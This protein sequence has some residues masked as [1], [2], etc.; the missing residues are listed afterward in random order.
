MDDIFVGRQ[1]IYNSKL[2]VMAYELLYRSNR[3]NHAQFLDG[4][5]A[6]TEVIINAFLEMGLE[7]LVGR[8][9]AF[10][11]LSRAFIV[12]DRPL[13]LSHKRVVLEVL[14]DIEPDAELIAAVRKLAQQGYIIALDDFVHRPEFEP[15]LQLA[16]IVKVDVMGV[17]PEV[18][19]RRVEKLRRPTLKLLAEKVETHEQFEHCKQLGFDYFQGYFFCRPN[20]VQRRVNP[21]NRLVLLGLM[22]ELQ[23]P[24]TD[25]QKLEQL[26]AQDATLTYRLLRYVNSPCVAMRRKIESLRRALVII[27]SN[28]IKNWITLILMTRLD[29]KPRELMV[30]ALVRAK[31]C[32]L[33]GAAHHEQGLDR[34]F[35]V[36]LLSTL[37][38]MLDKPIGELLDGL[39][40]VDETKA[41]LLRYEGL[42]GSVLKQVLNYEQGAWGELGSELPAGVY[43]QSYLEALQWAGDSITALTEGGTVTRDDAAA[44]SPTG[45]PGN[46][47]RG[48]GGSSRPFR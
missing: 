39:P 30:T 47:S 48:Q 8:H 7:Q 26:V 45:R 17:E 37:D 35:T 6:T 18:L 25:L 46:A 29:D 15:L 13:P 24:Q 27:G 42:L 34:F 40:L 32:E 11:N 36:G 44:G 10:I 38:A 41:A 4:D 20:V 16:H 5:V 14:E 3:E 21:A 22:A 9:P 43:K 19:T 12:G 33:L 28:T 1:P 23:H 31:M 2:E